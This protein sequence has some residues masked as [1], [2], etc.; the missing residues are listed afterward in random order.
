MHR[1][2]LFAIGVEADDT[3]ALQHLR[4]N[5][6]FLFLLGL[7]PAQDAVEAQDEIDRTQFSGKAAQSLIE[8]PRYVIAV[9]D[10][11]DETL[12]D[13]AIEPQRAILLHL[14]NRAHVIFAADPDHD[15]IGSEGRRAE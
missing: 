15:W 3:M 8:I 1:A 2:I 10:G 6:A 12:V 7:E 5:E 13:A 4:Y 9:G 14:L 11:E